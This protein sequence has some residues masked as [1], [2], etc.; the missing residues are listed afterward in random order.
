M[1]RLILSNAGVEATEFLVSS[2]VGAVT[3]GNLAL[4]VRGQHATVVPHAHLGECS[5]V[6]CG[7]VW[8]GVVWC[9]V[10]WCGVVWCGVV[11]CGV[12]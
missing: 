6:W 10:V 5:V 12:V 1:I 4:D 9:G 3:G 11:W 2:V 8:C 7:V